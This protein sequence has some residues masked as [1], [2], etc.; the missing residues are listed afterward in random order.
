M[1]SAVISTDDEESRWGPRRARFSRGGVGEWE[2]EE[3][4]RDRENASPA[5]PIR[6]VLPKLRMLP[7][8]T[9]PR[10]KSYSVYRC[11]VGAATGS[12][13]LHRLIHF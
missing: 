5:M 7:C 3:E 6:G 11:Y 10:D 9:T 12:Y 4:W 2:T 8:A 1:K 13:V